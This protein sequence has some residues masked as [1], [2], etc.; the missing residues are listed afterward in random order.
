MALSEFESLLKQVFGKARKYFTLRAVHESNLTFMCTASRWA[1]N[2]LKQMIRIGE[3]VLSR[4]GVI[5][6]TIEGEPVFMEV[7]PS[8]NLKLYFPVLCNVSLRLQIFFHDN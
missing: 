8:L 1:I 4:L 2:V 3:K 5:Q 6:L 7:K